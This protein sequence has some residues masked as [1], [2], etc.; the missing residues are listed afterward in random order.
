MRPNLQKAVNRRDGNP[1]RL[2]EIPQSST[3]CRPELIFG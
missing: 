3:C 1:Q 2:A